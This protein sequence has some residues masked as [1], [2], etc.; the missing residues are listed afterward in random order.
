MDVICR[1]MFF[2]SESGTTQ[3]TIAP[4]S[5][6]FNV[7]VINRATYPTQS[8]II[9]STKPAGSA[10]PD[11][12]AESSLTH[13]R[14]LQSSDS[15]YSDSESGAHLAQRRQHDGKVRLNALLGLQTLARGAPKQ[16]QP[17]WPKFLTS[18]SSAPM[19]AGSYKTPSLLVLIG[20]DPISTVR[21]AACVVLGHILENSKQYLAMAEEKA[22]Q[23]LT[24]SHTGILALSERV[25]LMTRELHVGL[26]SA[27]DAADK[28]VE[29][30]VIIQ[31]IKC[32]SSVVANC[33][34]ER[35]RPGLPLL[36]FN[37]VKRFMESTGK[38]SFSLL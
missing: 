34:Y 7:G 38:I 3:S 14:N 31:M 27:V 15:E 25:G 29:Q 37:A 30:S 2:T 13:Y 18:S 12:H 33:S 24:K 19:M 4:F 16:L 35:M 9:P 23:P 11:V 1:F 22:T 26:A 20:S 10:A 32:C 8:S 21:S 17:H 36:L 28:S 6:A 5:S